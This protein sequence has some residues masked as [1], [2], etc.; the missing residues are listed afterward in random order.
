MFQLSSS[1]ISKAEFSNWE[2]R[3]CEHSISQASHPEE[4]NL[5]IKGEK[6]GV[7]PPSKTWFH[8]MVHSAPCPALHSHHWKLVMVFQ[9]CVIGSHSHLKVQRAARKCRENCGSHNTVTIRTPLGYEADCQCSD[10]HPATIFFPC[11]NTEPRPKSFP[12]QDSLP[13]TVVS[14]ADRPS[15]IIWTR[16]SFR[17]TDTNRNDMSGARLGGKIVEK[18]GNDQI[19]LSPYRKVVWD[20]MN[21]VWGW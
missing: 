4:T 17:T 2:N 1:R 15:I 5:F 12:F 14:S 9:R 6:Y 18:K 10:H 16:Q 20:C 3:T 13:F 8:E 11:S 21:C 7:Q 19:C